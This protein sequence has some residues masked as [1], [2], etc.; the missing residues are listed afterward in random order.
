MPRVGFKPTIPVL[1][2]A[3]TVHV[4]DRAAIVIGNRIQITCL[5]YN[6]FD[7]ISLRSLVRGMELVP[8]TQYFGC[9]CPPYITLR[10]GHAM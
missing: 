10:V 1:D 8:C 9:C 7:Y 3:K 6:G 4:S 2:G 5:E